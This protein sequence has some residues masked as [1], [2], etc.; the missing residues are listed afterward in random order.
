MEESIKTTAAPRGVVVGGSIAGLCCAHALVAAGWEVKVIEKSASPPSGSPTGAGLG[1]DSQ[2]CRI[3]SRWISDPDLIRTSTF[4]LSIELS[5]LTDSENKTSRT[6]VRDDNFGFRAA[7]WADLHSILYK[8]LPAGIVLWGHQYL[9]FETFSNKPSVLVK[10]KV[11]RTDENVELFGD[12]LIAADGCLSS[13]RQHFLPDFKL[14][15]SGYIAWRGVL[16]F[17]GRE[18][19]GTISG[20]RRAYPELGNCLYFD[21]AH[22]TH[23][24]FYELKNKRLNWIWYIN[25]PE[26]ELK[27]NSMTM[28]VREDMITKMHEEAKNVW[29]P[30]LAK[31]IVETNE[32][33]INAIYDSDP[34]PQL[35]FDNVVLVGD[36]AHPTTPHGLRSTN[37]SVLDAAILGHC[38]EKWGLESL[39]YAL[40][41]FQKVRLPV[42]SSQVLHARQ[43]GRIKQGLVLQDHKVFD[44][45]MITPEECLQLQQRN[46]PFF[47]TTPFTC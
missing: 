28:K 17:S 41:E 42:V 32:P 9:S 2:S 45:R 31:V 37:M 14:R 18:S 13:I 33:F 10:A 25:G 12:L 20:I 40:D 4:P 38:L 35:I 36:A 44:P 27:G 6:L 11:L 39:T 29:V 47:G 15:Y 19:S 26:P 22:K 34:L 23:S 21:L 7:H 46:M 24:V 5:Q 8:S 30:E 16:D 3:L 1:L 43:L